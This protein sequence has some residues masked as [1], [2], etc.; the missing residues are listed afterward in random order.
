MVNNIELGYLLDCYGMFLTERQRTLLEMHVNEDY[1]LR[2]IAEH[3]NISRQGV[4]DA[5][6]RGEQQLVEM[7]A[8]LGIYKRGKA[9]LA[10]L[11]RLQTSISALEIPL[12]EQEKLLE[13]IETIRRI[14]EDGY[15]I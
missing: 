14:W 2:E 13:H 5:L 6:K 3:A 4:R 1:S 12:Q 9:L 11:N 10:E 15:G 8:H 7:E